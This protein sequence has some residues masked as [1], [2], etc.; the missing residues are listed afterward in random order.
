MKKKRLNF[1]F[2]KIKA[3]TAILRTFSQILPTGIELC[4]GAYG[5]VVLYLLKRLKQKKHILSVS[6]HL[7]SSWFSFRK[8]CASI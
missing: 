5:Y 6:R 4:F 1:N 8:N 3:H 2:C 7:L